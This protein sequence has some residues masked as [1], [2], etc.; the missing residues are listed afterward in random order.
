[1]RDRTTLVVGAVGL[2]AALAFW[3]V[4]EVPTASADMGIVTAAKDV[5]LAMLAADA[6]FIGSAKCK[7]CHLPEHKSW[8]KLQHSKAFETLKPN[9]KAEVK[10][11]FKLD[12]AKDYT[13][14]AA[15]VGCH[16]VGSGKPGGFKVGAPPDDQKHLLGV[17]C[18]NCP[19]AGGNYMA[20]HEEVMKSKRKYKQEEMHAAGTVTPTKE[21][22]VTCHNEKSPTHDASKPFDF[23]AKKKDGVHESTPLKQREG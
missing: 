1:M 18:E 6:E 16:T 22:C 21:T 11:K 5:S 3:G 12:P 13:T 2:A 15:C 19:G 20:V 9:V 10:T 7:K 17:G 8:E 23:E 14:D 4:S